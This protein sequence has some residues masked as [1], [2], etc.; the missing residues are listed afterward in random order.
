MIKS[1]ALLIAVCF[2]CLVD[3]Q[4]LPNPEEDNLANYHLLD[5]TCAGQ[6]H[7]EEKVSEDLE[8]EYK[9]CAECHD[10]LSNLDGPQHNIKHQESE[11]M[12]CVEC[13]FP[14]EQFDPRE[15]CTDCHDEDWKQFEAR[16]SDYRVGIR[17]RWNHY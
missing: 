3:A 17:I 7:Q 10:S 4:E 8:F 1:T 12:V 14:H 6:C 5:E 2:C 13:H 16:H 15:I 9:S 11:A